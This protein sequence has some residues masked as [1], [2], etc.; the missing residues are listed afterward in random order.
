[1]KCKN[2]RKKR[3]RYHHAT[4]PPYDGKFFKK[5]YECEVCGH[6]EGL[7]IVPF[8]EELVYQDIPP[9]G[10]SLSDH[11]GHSEFCDC[12]DCLFDENSAVNR[13]R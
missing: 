1:M 12:P 6:V 13:R 4:I 8:S 11:D 3:G 2:C 5:F 10:V 7:G 9:S